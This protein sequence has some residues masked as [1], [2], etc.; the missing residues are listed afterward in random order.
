MK[1]GEK[2]AVTIRVVFRPILSEMVPEKI[3]PAAPVNCKTDK[4]IPAIQILAPLLLRYTG[5]KMVNAPRIKDLENVK[6]ARILN[7]GI[8][9]FKVSF[10]LT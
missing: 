8:A 1:I 10:A 4:E 7:V 3:V 6:A 9:F 5:R 2:I